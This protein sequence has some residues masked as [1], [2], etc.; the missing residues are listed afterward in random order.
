RSEW[1]GLATHERRVLQGIFKDGSPVVEL[2]ELTNKFY[3]EIPGIQ[4][5]LF[6]RLI[7]R[8]YYRSRPDSVR[9]GWMFAAVAPGF[10]VGGGVALLGS[11]WGLAPVAFILAGVL[12]GLIVGMFGFHMPARTV[13]GARALEK[14]LGFEEFLHR[15]ES[16]RLE[17][18]VKTPE[19]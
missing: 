18:V 15:V 4:Q 17:R 5:S 12:V 2:S 16:D 7:Q 9:G 13:P 3:Q 1:N 10:L 6:D 11:R 19:L 14:V 8:G